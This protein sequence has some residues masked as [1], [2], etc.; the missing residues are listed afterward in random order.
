MSVSSHRSNNNTESFK[1][2][3]SD[4]I[5]SKYIE[6]DPWSCGEQSRLQ[7]EKLILYNR[8]LMA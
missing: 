3:E 8:T 2:L 5:A 7:N 6:Y 1:V 4:N